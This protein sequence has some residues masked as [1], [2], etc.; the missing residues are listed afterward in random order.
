MSPSLIKRY[1]VVF[2]EDVVVGAM[3]KFFGS[4]S[5]SRPPLH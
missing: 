4:A 5:R 1:G 2:H 3:K